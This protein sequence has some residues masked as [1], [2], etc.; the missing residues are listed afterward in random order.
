MRT[1]TFRFPPLIMSCMMPVSYLLSRP[2][3][4]ECED[5][6]RNIPYLPSSG[7]CSP[8]TSD[9]RHGV[10]GSEQPLHCCPSKIRPL[11]PPS[12]FSLRHLAPLSL[13]LLAWVRSRNRD[14]DSGESGG[15]LSG[16][17]IT[18]VSLPF[19]HPLPSPPGGGREWPVPRPERFRQLLPLPWRRR[20]G[21]PLRPT[22]RPRRPC[23]GSAARRRRLRSDALAGPPPPL[24]Q[25]V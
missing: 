24:P 6:V 20:H 15:G 3:Q 4:V 11:T 1:L 18:P 17:M 9:G 23:S 7:C 2:H 19:L 5:T 10:S 22:A 25:P 14:S 8:T 12:T 16:A 21:R 13:H